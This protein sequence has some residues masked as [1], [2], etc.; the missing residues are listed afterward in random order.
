ME[1]KNQTFLGQ[2]FVDFAWIPTLII[3]ILAI[4]GFISKSG[5]DLGMGNGNFLFGTAAVIFLALL[6]N[7][8]FNPEMRARRGL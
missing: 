7:I 4:L 8:V 1:N 2:F 5:K 3:V 6:G